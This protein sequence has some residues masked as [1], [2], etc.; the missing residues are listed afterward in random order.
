ME[1]WRDYFE[2]INELL[3]TGEISGFLKIYNLFQ[4]IDRISSCL[5]IKTAK[6][7]LDKNI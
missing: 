1:G 7:Q 5:H 3:V 2:H 4:E 6:E